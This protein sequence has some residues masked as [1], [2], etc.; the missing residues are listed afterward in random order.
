MSTPPLTLKAYDDDL[1][2]REVAP[3]GDDY[4]AI[5]KI[6]TNH[7]K[8]CFDTLSDVRAVLRLADRSKAWQEE[9]H[10]AIA[11]L[12]NLLL[13][14][15]GESRPETPAEPSGAQARFIAVIDVPDDR[16]PSCQDAVIWLESLIHHSTIPHASAFKVTTYSTVEDLVIDEAA[17]KGTF[18]AAVSPLPVSPTGKRRP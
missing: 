4:N 14:L 6:A 12:E 8:A 3:T 18:A 5:H 10:R 11:R 1:N 17:R 9:R 2:R 15:A 13:T 16:P 7:L